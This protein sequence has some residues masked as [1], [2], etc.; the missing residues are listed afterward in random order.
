M[1]TRPQTETAPR[2]IVVTRAIIR[3]NSNEV[4]IA[5]R[6]SGMALGEW[7]LAG[8]KQGQGENLI[9]TV[10]REVREELGVEFFPEAIFKSVHAELPDEQGRLWSTFFFV[11]RADGR[12]AINEEEHSDYAFVGPDDLPGYNLAF[13]HKE[14]LEEFFQNNRT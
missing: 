13:D 3:N 12:I 2:E 8:G 9:E 10:V 6:A 1:E 14:I 4:L 11:G 7:S 5:K